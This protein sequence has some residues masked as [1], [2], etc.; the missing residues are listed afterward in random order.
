MNKPTPKRE[1][2][3][4]GHIKSLGMIYFYSSRDAAEDF[5][6]FGHMSTSEEGNKY[7]L[8]IDKRFDFD[9][10]LAYIENYSN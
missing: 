6:E 9:E 3:I 2:A 7:T 8:F 4:D 10:V 1:V 5:R